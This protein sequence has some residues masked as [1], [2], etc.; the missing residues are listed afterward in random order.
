MFKDK[1]AVITGGALGI[2][3]ALVKGFLAH[4]ANVAFI[5]KN[6]EAARELVNEI[7]QN[8]DNVLFFHGDLSNPSDLSQFIHKIV[9]EYKSISYI[10]NNAM[11]A[12]GG[13][14]SNCS[15]EDFLHTLKVGVAAPYELV[16][17]AIP[18]LAEP[19]AIVHISSSRSSQ[20]QADTESYSAAKGG[21]AALTHS[22]MI[23]L[24]GKARVNAVSPGWILTD[25][26]EKAA[27]TDKKDPDY[28]Q[29]PSQTIGK[30]EDIVQAVLFLCDE[31]NQFING[32]DLFVDGGMS[33]QMI[34]HGDEGWIFQ[35]DTNL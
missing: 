18:H 12:R 34:Y 16:R 13:I 35:E 19:A 14:L 3:K 15:Y 27:V 1:T 21:I 2:G 23:S 9:E 4:G 26:D 32:E 8:G 31:K 24:K 7:N 30:P 20:S 28:A 10:V 5:D 29:H 33:K 11:E 17:L 22:M 6:E 25:E